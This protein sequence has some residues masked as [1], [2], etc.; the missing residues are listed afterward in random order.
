M[1]LKE[2]NS[3]VELFFLKYEENFYKKINVDKETFLV[4]LKNKYSED[5]YRPSP[6]FQNMLN[7]NKKFY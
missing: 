2:I 6:I 5:R 4:S 7:Q 3:L 1:E